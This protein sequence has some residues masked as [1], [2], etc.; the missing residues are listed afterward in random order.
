MAI[1]LYYIGV[2]TTRWEV[3]W[4]V[5]FVLRKVKSFVA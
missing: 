4:S 5:R 2:C 3:M 1:Q